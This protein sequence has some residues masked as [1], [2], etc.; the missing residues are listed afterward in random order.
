MLALAAALPLPAAAV[1]LTLALAPRWHIHKETPSALP[2]TPRI[3]FSFVAPCVHE[4]FHGFTNFLVHVSTPARRKPMGM[5]RHAGPSLSRLAARV[6]CGWLMNKPPQNTRF[7]PS[8]GPAIDGRTCITIAP[9]AFHPFRNVTAHDGALLRLRDFGLA[10]RKTAAD[11]DVMHQR[12]VK[13]ITVRVHLA[14]RH[15]DAARTVGPRPSCWSSHPCGY[16]AQTP[17]HARHPAAYKPP[18]SAALQILL[19]QLGTPM[20]RTPAAVERN[21]IPA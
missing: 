7:A 9:T 20:A 17:V 12:F 1:L 19:N 4:K 8:P 5:S 14:R 2:N 3:F 16:L 10:Q 11:V 13:T 6:F 15:S 18:A 21:E